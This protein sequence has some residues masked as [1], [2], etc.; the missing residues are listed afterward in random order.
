MALCKRNNIWWIRLSHNGKRIQRSTGTLNKLAA[1]E[2]HDRLKAD[3]WRKS[4][5]GE[6][7]DH[8]WQEAVVKWLDELSYK[9]SI[10]EDVSQFRWLNSYLHNKKLNEIDSC[11]IEEITKK[12]TKTNVSA[13]TVNRLLALI[14]AVLNRAEKVWKW[15]EKAPTV[16]MRHEGGKREK[17]LTQKKRKSY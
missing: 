4:K 7:P 6:E 10:K 5:L 15:I 1:Q 3:L 14:R 12:K 16:S 8:T 9:R 13:A 11:M 17:W 2:L